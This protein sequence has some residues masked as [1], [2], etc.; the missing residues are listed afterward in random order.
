MTLVDGK[1]GQRLTIT[2][3]AGDEITLQALRFGIGEGSSIQVQKNIP[4]GPVIVLRNQLEIAI[5][6][7][8][9]CLIEVRASE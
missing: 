4:G 5:G 6:R 8:L 1:D 3:T 2:R 7:Q 9:A